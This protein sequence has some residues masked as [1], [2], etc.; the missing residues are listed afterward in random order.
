MA[1]CFYCNP[2]FSGFRK[3]VELKIEAG[4]KEIP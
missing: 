3:L 2:E 1:Q 4:L